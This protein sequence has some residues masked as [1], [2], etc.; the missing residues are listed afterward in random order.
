[1]DRTTDLSA[2]VA[3]IV[4]AAGAAGGWAGAPKPF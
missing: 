1:M 4:L 3:G 2:Q